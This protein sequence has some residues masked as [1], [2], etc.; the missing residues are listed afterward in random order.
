M[1]TRDAYVA[2]LEKRA[3]SEGDAL[4]E[5]VPAVDSAQVATQEHNKNQE[6]HRAYLHTIFSNAGDV[7]TNQSAEVKKLFNNIP[8]DAVTSNPLI[9]VAR[10]PF[11]SILQ[12]HGNFLKTASPIHAEVAFNAFADELHKISAAKGRTVSR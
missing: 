9:K 7:Q 4:H 1:T 8:K 2:L 6:D 5:S 3:T 12:T 11:F 10:A